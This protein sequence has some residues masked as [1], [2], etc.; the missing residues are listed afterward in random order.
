MS[1]LTKPDIWTNKVPCIKGKN[2]ILLKN[3]GRW[4]SKSI[5]S[6]PPPTDI[7]PQIYLDNRH[8]TNP[9]NAPIFSYRLFPFNQPK[10]A[11]V[12]PEYCLMIHSASNPDSDQ[13][14]SKVTPA[15]RRE[16]DNHIHEFDCS[17]R[18][19]LGTDI[20]SDSWSCPQKNK[21]S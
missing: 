14:H 2:R 19:G 18:N 20:W 15:L 8:S 7:L 1:L 6:L 9:E 10:S 13:C 5:L 3:L 12:P 4:Q 17:L 21:N 11:G 16:E